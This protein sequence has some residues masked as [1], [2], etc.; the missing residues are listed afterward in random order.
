MLLNPPPNFPGMTPTNKTNWFAHDTM[1][2]R[3]PDIID[4]I[5]ARN[6][7]YPDS[8]HAAFEHLRQQI[9]SNAAVPM[10]EPYAPDYADWL[11]QWEKRRND[12]WLNTPWFFAETYFY[13]LVIEIVRWWET[14]RDP[15]APNKAEEY[16]GDA[17]WE[18]LR[19]ALA[20]QGTQEERLKEAIHGTLWGNRIDLSYALSREHGTGVSD[21]DFL[22]DESVAVVK[23]L[24]STSGTVHLIADNA[25]TELA[26]DLVLADQLL[27]GITDD[28]VLHLKMHPTFVSDATPADV[29]HFLKMLEGGERGMD[30]WKFGQ[31][32]YDAIYSGRLRLIPN[33]FWNSSRLLWEMPAHLVQV[34][35]TARIV[36][37]KGDANYRRMVGDALWAPDTPF[38]DV[39]GYFP[40]PLVALRSLKSDPIVGLPAGKADQLDELDPTWRFN[41]KRGVIQFKP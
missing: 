20:M 11:P 35:S 17:L 14:G 37:I 38:A 18:L 25:G 24:M 33:L 31:R 36:F 3:V 26:M 29:W 13:R 16:A 10:L 34:F 7:E 40:A 28:A 2:R 22:V 39:T 8:V 41:G 5:Q 15:F 1:T 32:M 30:A 21:G 6:P 19:A 12:T 9:V 27:N 4:D 23:H